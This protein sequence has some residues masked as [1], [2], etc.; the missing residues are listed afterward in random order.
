L[1]AADFATIE[2]IVKLYVSQRVARQVN[3][4]EWRETIARIKRIASA[5][6]LLLDELNDWRNGYG[7]IWKRVEKISGIGG[8]LPLKHDDIYPIISRLYSA[9][10]AAALQAQ[11]ERQQGAR[12]SHQEPWKC[13][14]TQLSDFWKKKGGSVTAPKSGRAVYAQPS[15]FV[16][17]V[18]T[19]MKF[20][21]PEFLKEYTAS[22]GA[23][24]TAISK[25]LS[26]ARQKASGSFP[27]KSASNKSRHGR[28]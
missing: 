9:S 26:I 13:F 1:S 24:Q 17:L 7:Q 4:I 18:W 2:I 14:V 11:L 10:G 27:K 20:A 15:P 5:S 3:P 16:H 28:R 25:V 22:C 21:V 19:L 12:L 6:K 8:L 23:M